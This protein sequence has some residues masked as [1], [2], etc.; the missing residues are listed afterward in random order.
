M[1]EG[2]WSATKHPPLLRVRALADGGMSQLMH[3]F[4]L[5][6]ADDFERAWTNTFTN[7]AVFSASFRDKSPHGKVRITKLCGAL[8]R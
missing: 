8:L 7:G 3:R 4:T 5:L 1:L 2:K 6:N